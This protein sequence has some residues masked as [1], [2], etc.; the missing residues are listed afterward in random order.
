MICLPLPRRGSRKAAIALAVGSGFVSLAQMSPAATY[1]WTHAD[2]SNNWSVAAN[3]TKNDGTNEVPPLAP[4]AGEVTRLVFT[5]SFGVNTTST[6]NLADAI[7][8]DALVFDSTFTG[9]A[10]LALSGS[11]TGNQFIRL[12]AGGMTNLQLGS[13][14]NAGTIAFTAGSNRKIIL[15]ANQTWNNPN[16]FGIISQRRIMEGAFAVTKTGAG[17]IELQADNSL[18]TGGLIINEGVIRLSGSGNALGAGPITVNTANGVAISASG[19]TQ[20]D[21]TVAGAV[22]LGGTGTFGLSGSWN[23]AFQQP[24]TLL[25][26]KTVNVSHIATFNS[27]IDGAGFTWTKTGG[28][29]MSLTQPSTIA[30]F[31]IQ[32]GSIE[33]SNANQLGTGTAAIGMGS[34]N[35]GGPTINTG[36]IRAL[37]S[38]ESNRDLAITAGAIGQV[39]T[40]NFKVVFGNV[41]GNASTTFNKLGGGALVVN[42]VR[43]GSL[44]IAT[45]GTLAIPFN[46]GSLATSVVKNLLIA[47]DATPTAKL[48]LNNNDLVIDYDGASPIATVTAQIVAGRNGGSWNGNGIASDTAGTDQSKGLGVADNADLHYTSFSGQTVDDSSVLVKFTYLGDSDVNGQVD[49]NDLGKLA[50]SWQQAGTWI[51]GDFDYNGTIDVNDLGLLAT[52]WQAGVGNPLGPSLEQAL[53]SLGLPNVSVPEPF[54]VGSVL[55]GAW[56]LKRPRRRA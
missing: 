21:Q 5:G 54:G 15:T 22:S 39:D 47:G 11:S 27:S 31:I 10:T 53:N 44:S 41:D 14:G 16:V 1:T 12:G 35:P 13:A 3:W 19:T 40:N 8:V 56:W 20:V 28:G 48:E 29:T 7:E 24:V 43:T 34:V 49:V 36:S 23:F 17:T 51:N 38:I 33:I 42:H 4:L 30:G 45:G 32:N 2:V 9:A 52:N 55:L 50:T 46:G 18:F 6:Q 26:D 37:D 25:N